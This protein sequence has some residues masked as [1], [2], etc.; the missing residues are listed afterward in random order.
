MLIEEIAPIDDL[1]STAD[2]R[3]R[4]AANLLAR[5]LERPASGRSLPIS[6]PISVRSAARIR[7]TSDPTYQCSRSAHSAHESRRRRAR[8]SGT[9]R[10]HAVSRARAGGQR[11]RRR[12]RRLRGHR[13]CRARSPTSRGSRV[14]RIAPSTLR[15]TQRLIRPRRTSVAALL[16]AC[17][18][19]FRLWRT[20]RAL[21]R[22]DLVLV[23]NPPQFPTLAVT[24][25][26]LRRRGVRFVIDWHNLGYTL[27][28]P[29][30]GPLAS[31]G[32][33]SRA[34]SSGATRGGSTR[35]LCVSRGLAAFLESRFGVQQRARALRPAG[36]GVRRRS[37]APSAN[38][39]V[40]RC[41]RGS[42]SAAAVVGF[43]VC[44]T[45]WTEDE[46]FDVVI[47]AVVRLEERIRGWEAAEP[48]A[49]F[50]GSRDPRHR[51][52]RAARRVRA[53]ICRP[54]GAPDPAAR[55]LARARRLPARRRQ[56]R[57]RACACIGPRRV[58]TFR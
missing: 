33:A 50:S 47:E 11:R 12:S 32:A 17:R 19:S 7:A 42:A 3:T 5:F 46:D 37:S 53:A 27:L 8:R 15:R 2:Y 21:Q 48:H 23:Q 28:Q 9:Q 26:S 4:V 39:S 49:A 41:S 20:L 14:H 43:I 1:R 35:N 44:P 31:G 18:L 10:P 29:A 55:A 51:R 58:S 24:W 36:V 45:S 30:A 34:G 40:R 38:S 13:R 56:R 54:A 52:R 25:L 57:P 6:A 16:D 22:P